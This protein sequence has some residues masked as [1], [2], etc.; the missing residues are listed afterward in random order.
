MTNCP[1]CGSDNI[2]LKSKTNIDWK[3]VVDRV[4]FFGITDA[5]ESVTDEY[6]N[7]NACL[8]CGTSWKPSELYNVLELIQNLTAIKLDLSSKRDRTALNE[9]TNKLDSRKKVFQK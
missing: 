9:F 3:N 5:I 8:D 4:E 2:Q 7:V 6:G 1:N